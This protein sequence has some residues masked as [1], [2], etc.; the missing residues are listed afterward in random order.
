ML[1]ALAV[2]LQCLFAVLVVDE[3]AADEGEAGGEGGRG[4]SHDQKGLSMSMHL[5]VFLIHMHTHRAT[6]PRACHLLVSPTTHTTP[7]KAHKPQPK[8]T[9]LLEL[10]AS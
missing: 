7:N 1:D 10:E 5:F 8:Q 4:L 3:S 2:E 9:H 6:W